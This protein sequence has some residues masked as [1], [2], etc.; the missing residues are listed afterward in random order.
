MSEVQGC[1]SR[2]FFA[3]QF[4]SHGHRMAAKPLAS[5]PQSKG[6]RGKQRQKA[7]ASS[8][9][10]FIRKPM[11]FPEA[12][13]CGFLCHQNSVP[14]PPS[15]PPVGSMTQQSLTVHSSFAKRILC[16]DTGRGTKK[17]NIRMTSAI[18][19]AAKWA[20]HCTQHFTHPYHA[21][22]TLVYKVTFYT[23]NEKKKN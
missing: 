9:S 17:E 1:C 13:S 3:P 7:Y 23:C 12:P 10:I 8:L 19:C 21:S 6:T 16:V 5:H 2:L 11:A 14:L 4:C 15:L 20:K 22:F 18:H